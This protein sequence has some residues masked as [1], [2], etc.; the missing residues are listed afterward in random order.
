METN[1]NSHTTFQNLWDTAKS[2]LC[3]KLIAIGAYVK[4]QERYQIQELTTHLQEL[5]KQQQ[6]DP[7]NNR[8]QEMIKT[9]EE[10]NQIEIL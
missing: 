5:E 4:A 9:R 2:V 6:N 3:G 8:K 7:T 10:I 1:E